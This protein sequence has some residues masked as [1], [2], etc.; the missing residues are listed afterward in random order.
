M[1]EKSESWIRGYATAIRIRGTRHPVFFD[2]DSDLDRE[3][4]IAGLRFGG[5]YGEVLDIER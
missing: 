5:C 4:F 1:N 3:D 2:P